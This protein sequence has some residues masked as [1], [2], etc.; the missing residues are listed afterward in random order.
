[1]LFTCGS[2]NLLMHNRTYLLR[3]LRAGMNPELVDAALKKRS[4]ADNISHPDV[5]PQ[6]VMVDS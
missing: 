5:F 6:D 3:C 1:M 4:P 2:K